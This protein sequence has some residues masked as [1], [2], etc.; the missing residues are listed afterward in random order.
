MNRLREVI[1]TGRLY[2]SV[3]IGRATPWYVRLLLATG[4]LYILLPVD[5]IY[6]YIPL[7]GFV[8]DVTVGS[9][10]IALAIRLLPCKLKEN[11]RRRAHEAR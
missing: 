6:D 3:L 11:I 4:L 1:R 7:L 8:D 9:L 10:I 2:G 5:F